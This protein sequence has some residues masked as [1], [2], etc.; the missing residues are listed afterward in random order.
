M[1]MI[2]EIFR[3]D[4]LIWHVI[5]IKILEDYYTCSNNIKL[6][7]I[8]FRGCNIGITDGYDLLKCR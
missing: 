1:G 5:Y 8:S 7:L 4:A 2:Y 3:F 6:L